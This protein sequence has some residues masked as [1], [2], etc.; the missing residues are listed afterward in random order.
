MEE[1]IMKQTKAQMLEVINDSDKGKEPTDKL[2]LFIIWY[3]STEQE[4]TRAEMDKFEESLK[5]AG[6]DTTSLAY[7]KQVRT[8]TRMTMLTTALHLP[9]N[10]Q[11]H[12]VTFSAGSLP[13]PL[14]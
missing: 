6:A 4:I 12:L 2:R 7:V 10:H 3:L 13:F 1:S 5:T 8:T 11:A 9:L 14:V